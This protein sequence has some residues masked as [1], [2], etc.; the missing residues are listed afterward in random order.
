[1]TALLVRRA[2]RPRRR[3]HGRSRRPPAAGDSGQSPRLGLRA[4]ERPVRRAAVRA[5]APVGQRRGRGA[6]RARRGTRRRVRRDMNRRAPRSS[7]CADEVPLA[8]RP[9]RLA[10]TRA[11]RDLVRLTRAAYARPG[12][13]AIGRDAVPRSSP[14]DARE[15]RVVQNRNALLWLYPGAI[16]VKTGFTAPPVLRCRAAH[17]GGRVTWSRSS[18]A[19]PGEAFS[20]AAALLDYGFAAFERADAR[21]RR[22]SLRR[23]ERRGRDGPG[24]RPARRR[25]LVPADGG[26]SRR[27][28]RSTPRRPSRRRR[29]ERIGTVTVL[30]AGRRCG[31]VPLVVAVRSRPRR[32]LDGPWWARGAGALVGRGRRDRC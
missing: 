13:R 16:G 24:V 11:P 6:R 21:A 29:G 12:S 31:R 3:R 26:R 18:S 20:D 8:E 28:S 17:A 22:A 25:G 23:R 32:R 15:P 1:M 30:V 4:G 2:H 19:P 10:V 9:R 7:A 5:A 14:V 27:P